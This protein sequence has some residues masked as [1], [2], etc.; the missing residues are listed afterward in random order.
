LS[1]YRKG[2]A[3]NPND[4]ETIKSL[5]KLETKKEVFSYF[6]EPDIDALIKNAPK[7]TDYPDDNSVILNE[8]VQ[9]VVYEQGG[10]EE[11]KY[12][13]VKILTQKGIDSWKEYGIDYDS[14]QDLIFE[15]AEVIK[16]NGSKVPAERNE[17]NLVFT[18]LEV[19]DVVNIRYKLN[20]YAKAKLS[21]YF[22]DSFYFTHGKPYVT[23]KYSLLIAKNQKFSYKFSQKPIDPVKTQTDEFDMYVWQ[24]N[25]GES[26]Q[27]EDKMPPLD[28]VANILYLTSIPDWKFIQNWY[29]DIGAGKV[30]SNYEVK[31]VINDLFAGKTNLTPMQKVEKIYNYITGNIS[32]SSVSFRQSGIVP[33]SPADVLN[34]RIGDCKDVS[35]LFVT[36]CKEAGIK[37]NLV[38]AKTRDNGMLSMPLPGI[39]FNHCMAK[40]NLNNQDYYMELTSQYLPFRSIY[41]GEINS[42][43]LDIGDEKSV[44]TTKYL[45]PATRLGN[46]VKRSTNISFADKNMLITEK[47]Y[48]TGA[49]AANLRESYG[50]LSQKD[51]IK[52]IKEAIAT[53]YPD[54]D[55]SKLEYKNIDRKN[56]I[57]TVY[58]DLGYQLNNVTKTIGGMSIF[59][60]PWSS[61]IDAKDLQI[62]M[63]R[64]AGI[65]LSQLFNLDAETEA[66]T[67]T[68]PEG[69][70]MIE[71]LAPVTLQ[72]DI[73]E[74][75]ITPKQVGNKLSFTRT[76]KLKKDFVPA[77]KVG[78]FNTFFKKMVESDN[79]E[80][81]MR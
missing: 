74:Y 80:L 42:I 50:E 38:L 65:D 22:W 70:K 41:A 46:D 73:I 35:T 30:R 75:T 15:T 11:R 48:E 69:K 20:N 79:K 14:W 57:D 43:L 54:V 63:P 2:L 25:K 37:A 21:G 17:N 36:M 71:S 53:S 47:T 64:S 62:N 59:S 44:P 52:K 76:F 12:L 23:S 4:Y 7:A 8:E 34:T 72:S 18:N 10:S 5:R 61:K 81:A 40:V 28:D 31:E 9:K 6:T 49:L 67:V 3:I 39:D 26:L 58:F 56:P 33:Q 1:Y 27:Y 51:R 19:G 13:T 55:I 29:N 78:E 66:I 68:L 77:D 16:A 60:L 24:N 32:Y 45:N